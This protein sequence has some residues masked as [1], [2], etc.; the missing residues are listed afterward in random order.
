MFLGHRTLSKR[1][2][3]AL[4]PA[5][6]STTSVNARFEPFGLPLGRNTR[7]GA[8]TVDYDLRALPT[9]LFRGRADG[10]STAACDLIR[11]RNLGKIMAMPSEALKLNMVRFWQFVGADLSIRGSPLVTSY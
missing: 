3:R 11:I 10:F 9:R 4:W 6:H 8:A 5:W 2:S 7:G 1:L